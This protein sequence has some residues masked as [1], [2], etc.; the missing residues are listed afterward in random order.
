MSSPN[1]PC[2]GCADISATYDSAENFIAKKKPTPGDWVLCAYC[3]TIA[4]VERDH[5]LRHA[6]ATE[7]VRL[8]R[9]SPVM[10]VQMHFASNQIQEGNIP[11][12][13]TN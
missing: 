13:P 11:V 9:D 7:F 1:Q 8:V 6:T 4:R 3:G 12:G 10:A 5:T 2:P